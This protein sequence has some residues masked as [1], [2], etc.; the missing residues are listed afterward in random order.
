MSRLCTKVKDS[1][2]N[3][4]IF[5]SD[6]PST[7]E[8]QL[9]NELLSTRIFLFLFIC[10]LF[11]LVFYTTLVDRNQTIEIDSPNVEQY[12]RLYSIY[13]ETL[14]C[15]C[16]QISVSY[17][18]FT[19]LNYQFHQ[20]CQSQFIE[21]DWINYI[22]QY[23]IQGQLNLRDF[24]SII[25]KIFQ[26]LTSFCSLSEQRIR[27]SLNEFYSHELISLQLKSFQL[28]QS[29]MQSLIEQ[30][31][32]SIRN[33]FLLSISMLR[34]TTAN[35]QIASGLLT[36]YYF[37]ATQFNTLITQP[38]I[39]QNC[40]CQISS[41]CFQQAAFYN[42]Q[43]NLTLFELPGFYIG[44]YVIESL[45]KSNLQCFYNQSCIQ[46]LQS[47]LNFNSTMNV[48]QLNRSLLIRFQENSTIEDLI[49][50]L[51][52]EQWNSSIS[53]ENYYAGC[54]PSACSYTVKTRNSLIY[55]VT[56]IIGLIGGLVTTL[57]LIVPRIVN[58]WRKKK[59]S[60][61]VNVYE[62]IRKLNIF[63]SNPPSEN[64]HEL[65]NEKISTICF[66][67]VLLVSMLILVLYNSF[68][69]TSRTI[70]LSQPTME[71]YLQFYSKYSQTLTCSC[72]QISI[73]YHR[74][75]QI[76]NQFHE[77]CQS[78]FVSEEWFEYLSQQSSN[79]DLFI[80]DFRVTSTSMF[81][82]LN[83]FCE[84]VNKTITNNRNEFY[85]TDYLS[86]TVM[87]F[88]L[89]QT[90]INSIIQQ[91]HSSTKTQFLLSISSIR[92]TTQSNGLLSAHLTNYHY[93]FDQTGEID[94]LA[95]KWNQCNCIYS[96]Q[97][98]QQAAFYNL[99]GNLTLFELPGFYIGCYVIESLLKS[100]L[101]C[102]Y[103]QSCI[104]QLQSY[105]N[106]NSTMN[107]TQLNRSLL[108]RFQ[109]N[110]TIEDL[111]DE[112]MVEQWNSS[113]SF[114]NYYD[115]C[116]PSK[117]SYTIKSKNTIIYIVTSIIGL[118]GGLVTTLKL[119]TPR[120]IKYLRKQKEREETKLNLCEKVRCY[121]SV[122]LVAIRN[123]NIF[124]KSAN[125]HD[126]YKGRLA[127]RLFLFVL[128][129][130]LS[131]LLLYTSLIN[132]KQLIIISKPTMNQY[133]QLNSK[134]SQT[135]TCPCSQISMNYKEIIEMSYKFHEICSSSLLN[136]DWIENLEACD[137]EYPMYCNDF[138][139]SGPYYFQVL[140][141][142]C[143]FINKTIVN[144]LI[145]F[146]SRKYLSSSV[147]NRNLFEKQMNIFI[148]EFIRSTTNEFLLSISMIRQLTYSNALLSGL[149]YNFI[150]EV[151]IPTYDVLIY[152][153]SY[154]KCLC[155]STSS[156]V[157]RSGF[158]LSRTGIPLF[159][160]DGFRKGC[161]MIDSLLKSNLECF[162]NEICIDGIKAFYPNKSSSMNVIPLN[163]SLLNNFLLNSTMQ[164]VTD[165]LMIEQWNSSI[166]FDNYF[167]NCAPQQCRYM[168]TIRNSSIYII[169]TI[170]GLIGGLIT[171]LK[172][173]VPRFV[174][175]ILF[176]LIKNKNRIFS[177]S[178]SQTN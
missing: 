47:Y 53:F 79:V 149:L 17:Q 146:H 130:L 144:R 72:S 26:S 150:I 131:I 167:V 129:V 95:R 78:Q 31:Q 99:Q 82:S 135:L 160:V 114:E 93:T 24:R 109:E 116:R 125:E 69:E 51:M 134:Y 61:K 152:S 12:S 166:S 90:E 159:I 8:Y 98:F 154:N 80:G 9:K 133:V 39:Y 171:A 52:V 147:I 5:S 175:F 106:F 87:S 71:Q 29:Q 139:C 56:T 35:N 15:P 161:F 60:E 141:A 96:S 55:I 25:T 122:S 92:S 110:S 1:L 11:V 57:K 42:P 163:S 75:I 50:E 118:I 40:S 165:Q 45:L 101:Q 67:F 62:K 48:T 156:C 18:T 148:S 143:Q 117:C 23:R 88:E 108:I 127:T 121:F 33:Q 138:R 113:I 176:Y 164:L 97:C 173:T 104:Q 19:Q 7:D 115:E 66:L 89:F 112:L 140:S 94:S 169:T 30:F 126:I 119:T 100:N 177:I 32:N 20:I 178:S 3:M 128:I 44:C 105:L 4:N 49:D 21:Q 172:L 64:E 142:Y 65:K 13:E 170:I 73:N 174:D 124:A 85:S 132:I 58:Y 111:I 59:D 54:E 151:D 168:R 136:E 63:E 70:D 107:V 102:F 22:T 14:T 6:P 155:D 74:F 91:F 162:Y 10:S 81:Q 123:M 41:Q 46:Q 86:S 38:Q 84:L 157:T 145:E 27:N 16:R 68:I 137:V 34:K 76:E 77:I 37:I 120:I 153:E 103:N 36:N 83:V 2:I 158:F 43:G 28:F